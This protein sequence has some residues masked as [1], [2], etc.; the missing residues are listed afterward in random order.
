MTVTKD[1]YK[2]GKPTH[3]VIPDTQ[4]KPGV[5]TDHLEW[6]GRWAAEKKPDVII[7][8]G[9]HADMPSLSSYDVGK[10]SFEGRRYKDDIDA[11]IAGMQRFLQPIR[12]EQA[13][14]RANKKREWNPR[15]V[16]TL[17]NH[18]YRIERAVEN[19]PKLDGVLSMDDLQYAEMGFEVYPFLEPVTIDG[20]VYCHYFTTGSMG[21]P[22]TSARA[23]AMKKHMSCVMGHVQQ[24]EIDLSQKRADGKFITGLFSG[25]F[26]DHDE[27]YLG[28]Q[29]NQVRKQVWMFYGV[30]DGEFDIQ[31]L[32]LDYLRRRYGPK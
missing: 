27:S 16:I 11:A 4:V 21:R 3:M 31:Q 14:L 15:L 24:T 19:D 6:A 9:D 13:R 30:E 10:R 17:G 12:E 7:H 32:P 1:T 2:R 23:L 22:V 8:I 20:V 26:Y 25:C 5:S 28:V 29:G 18:E